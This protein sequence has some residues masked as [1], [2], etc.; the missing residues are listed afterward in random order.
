MRTV[1]DLAGNVDL[2]KLREAQRHL[3]KAAS[4]FDEVFSNE[5]HA[6]DTETVREPFHS[7]L[8]DCGRMMERLV[9]SVVY[10]DIFA[11][12][13]YSRPDSDVITPQ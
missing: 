9:G 12:L 10:N 11:G 8:G 3:D 2:A 1:L 13:D 7:A 4:L 5:G 6:D